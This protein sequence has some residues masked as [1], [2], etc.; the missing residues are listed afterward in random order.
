MDGVFFGFSGSL[1][2]HYSLLMVHFLSGSLNK[3]RAVIFGYNIVF[4]EM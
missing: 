1:K 2:F 4:I 3:D